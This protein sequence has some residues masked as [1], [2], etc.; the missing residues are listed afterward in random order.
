MQL[1]PNAMVESAGKLMAQILQSIERLKDLTVGLVVLVDISIAQLQSL[2]RSCRQ[3]IVELNG[4][5]YRESHVVELTN[6]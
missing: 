1:S 2:K 4:S 3:Q 6:I 5:L